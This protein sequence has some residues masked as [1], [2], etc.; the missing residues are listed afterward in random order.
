MRFTRK[1]LLYTCE[2]R[3]TTLKPVSLDAASANFR[4]LFFSPSV[5]ALRWDTY[6]STYDPIFLMGVA[7]TSESSEVHGYKHIG[8]HKKPYRHFDSQ[9]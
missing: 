4:A 7:S 3:I 2:G 6:C 8:Y 5:I 1:N 9:I